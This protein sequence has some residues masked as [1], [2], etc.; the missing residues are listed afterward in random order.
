MYTVSFIAILGILCMYACY[1]PLCACYKDFYTGNKNGRS[2][3]VEERDKH[4]GF[5]LFLVIFAVALLTRFIAAV[6]YKGY[7]T[8]MNCFISWSDMVFNGGFSEFYKS[9]SF[10]DYPPGYMY[11]LYVIGAIRSLFGMAY[12]SA[13]TRLLVK[14][15]AIIADMGA[16]WLIY[17]VASRHTKEIGAAVI[18]AVYLFCPA[19]IL[20]SA[21]WGQTDAVFT[22]FVALVCYLV[23]ERKLIPSYFVFA[24]GILIKPQTLIF[25]PVL[26]CG[27]ADQVFLENFNW[28]KFFKN[29]GL[30]L[31]A[32]L[33]I[34]VLMLPYGFN[35]AFAQYT[36]TLGSYEYASVNAYNIWT[37]LG[38]N[39]TGQ[40]GY[41]MGLTYHTWGMAA[42]VVTVIVSLVISLRCKDNHSKYYFIGAFIVTCVFMFS[43]R[44]HERYIFPAML[45]LVLCYGVR[46]RKEI[47]ILYII[48]SAAAFYNIAHVLFF[49]DVNNFDRLEPS[50]LLISAGM[51]AVTVYMFYVAVKFFWNNIPRESEQAEIAREADLNKNSNNMKTPR[52]PVR[53]SSVLV[54][55]TKLDYIAMFA[56]VVIY[57]VVAFMRL[58]NMSAPET[59]YSA[60]KDGEILLDL[61]EEKPVL[62]MWDF[63]GYREEPKYY[64]QYSGNGNDW[65]TLRG[66]GSEWSGGSVFAW[67]QTELGIA[68]RYIKISPATNN[69]EDSIHELVL[70]DDG[71]NLLMPANSHDYAALFDE[72]D[73]FDG[74]KSNLNSTYFDEIYHARTAYEMIHHL[75]CYENTHPPLGKIFIACGVLIFGMNPFGWRFAGTLFGVLMLPVIYNF[76]KKFFKETWISVVT[77]LLFAFDF[78]HFVQ[79][80]IATI[81]VFVTLFIILSYYFMYCYTKYSFYDTDLK[82]TFIPL[83][84]CGI[85]MGLG[86]ASK[87]TG[88]YSSAGLCIIFFAQMAQRFREYIYA[89]NYPKGVT[90]GIEHRDIINSFYNKF[91]KT[92]GFCCI[93]FV[94]IPVVIYTLSYIPFSDGTDRGLIERMLNAQQT[95]FNYHTQLT[96]D[97]YFSSKWYQWPIMYKPM[98]Y[99]DGGVSDTLREGISAFGNPLVW[100]AGIP[101][102][103][104]M[105]YLI[106]KERD[107]NAAFLSVGYLSQY[108]PWFFVTRTVFIYHYFPSVPFITIMLGYSIH[109]IVQKHPSLKIAAYVY[110][111][112]TIGLFI[113]FYPVLAGKGISP[114]FA[115]RWLKWLDSWVLLKT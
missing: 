48:L 67:N 11:I 73:M 82:K 100:W 15:P 88:I 50:A 23:T 3:V 32:I 115:V 81:D 111:A 65:T 36:D 95:M 97:H 22:F 42:I 70:L 113:L 45:L 14:L 20:D 12:D 108:V 43:V 29:L 1:R 62:E 19:V 61:G 30:G 17:R 40:G 24:V 99:Y 107:R 96:D 114:D 2:V 58:G 49:Y 74:R 84:L 56:I 6:M 38:L 52:N 109:R 63:L 78:M 13:A 33:L 72:Q 26:I 86:W 77:T 53:A 69:T 7:E 106:Y 35:D 92:I 101:A 59:S 25:T 105:L 87:W 47:Y 64:I 112:C 83:G 46:Q 28:N 41:I 27:I 90:E 79:T 34:V 44:M 110:T 21:V 4:A 80:R 93:F 85:A 91:F 9:E 8:D 102:F 104:Y 37:L 68:A 54:K 76:S 75:Y 103:I 51:L 66:E 89:N 16:G 60:A 10:T 39:W 5:M 55:M 18:S 71:V 57:S 94:V 31:A 98:W